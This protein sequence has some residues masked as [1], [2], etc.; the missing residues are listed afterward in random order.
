M[1]YNL[2]QIGRRRKLLTMTQQQLAMQAQV[3]QSLITK[4]E[5]GRLKDVSHSVAMRILETLTKLEHKEEKKAKDIM[6]RKIITANPNDFVKDK[7]KIMKEKFISQM[8]VIDSGNVVGT[9]SE[10][11]IL[12]NLNK[13]TNKINVSEVMAEAPPQVPEDTPVSAVAGLLKSSAC[14]LVVRKGKPVG[15]ITKSDL[16]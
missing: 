10:S 14:V 16:I 5:N 7:I 3:S 9:L 11:S 15:I 2:R 13:I 1:E 12:E 4:I 8:P 6:A